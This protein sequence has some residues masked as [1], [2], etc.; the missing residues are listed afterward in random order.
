LADLAHSY[1]PILSF[2]ALYLE[3]LKEQEERNRRLGSR[4]VSEKLKLEG[5]LESLEAQLEAIKIER[6]SAINEANLR[7]QAAAEQSKLEVGRAN[8]RFLEAQVEREETARLMAASL[9][10]NEARLQSV[11]AEL[12]QRSREFAER[13]QS[14][15]MELQRASAELAGIQRSLAWRVMQVYGKVKHPYLMPFYKT[16]GWFKHRFLLPMLGRKPR[17]AGSPIADSP[18]LVLSGP[19]AVDGVQQD[20]PQDAQTD[21]FD[22]GSLAIPE[23]AEARPLSHHTKTV[24]IIVCVHNA[25]DE[26]RECLESVEQNTSNSYSLIIV[27]DGSESRTREFLLDFVSAKGAA[28]ISNRSARGYTLAANQGLRASGADYVVLLNSD[29]IV[30]PGWLD[31]LIDCVE[32]DPAIGIAG[33]LSNAAT[34]QSIPA[35]IREGQFAVNELPEGISVA[36]MGALV[37]EQSRRLYPRVAFLNG[38]CLLLR[39]DV[40]S[41]VGLFDETNF[42]AGYGEENDYALRAQKAGWRLA[43]ADDAYVYHHLSRSYSEDRRNELVPAAND[44][45][46]RLHGL[47]LVSRGVEQCRYDRTLE[48]IRA[49]HQVLEEREQ[50][51]ERG[52][53]RWTGKKVAFILPVWGCGGGANIALHEAQAMR[54]MGVDARVINLEEHR[55]GFEGA[56]RDNQVPVIYLESEEDISKR[57]GDFDG[58]LA[59]YYASVYWLKGLDSQFSTAAL[60][61]YIQDFEPYFFAPGSGEYER[62]WDSYTLYPNLIRIAKTD[63][64]RDTIK[65]NIGVESFV[66]GATVDIDLYRPRPRHDRDWP[67]RPLRILAMLRVESSRRAPLA[68][69]E[70]LSAIQ[71]TH[72]DNIEIIVFGCDKNSAEYRGLMATHPEMAHFRSVGVLNRRQVAWLMNEI[73]LFIDLSIFQ[74]QGLT[75]MEAM[76][77]GAVVMV[78]RVGGSTGFVKDQENGIV[79]DAGSRTASIEA[80]NSLILEP[81]RRARLQK[82]AIYD[83]CHFYLEKGAYRTLEAL[84]SNTAKAGTA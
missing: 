53:A 30:T 58:V 84:F 51:I 48:G 31:R 81:G 24:E 29:T 77:S 60:G 15:S 72:G 78:P 39:R 68:T 73:D 82:Q 38:F 41:S 34:W 47:T 7:S 12:G 36:R 26:L 42:G 55:T 62:A 54:R 22:F 83:I 17:Y 46:Q 16:Y 32:S 59:T 14:L 64:D 35:T 20:G 9:G 5:R 6:D 11:V 10:L 70:V 27:D 37:A 63:W 8:Q 76:C 65:A 4:L 61:Y 66:G 3:L 19:T 44:T 67:A 1:E 52:R 2:S 18:A 25:L 33:P 57:L 21:H 43:I 45:L 50:T 23:I 28:L 13:E 74:A 75:A 80:A 40:I 79:I 56:Y 71:R 49:R 69:L